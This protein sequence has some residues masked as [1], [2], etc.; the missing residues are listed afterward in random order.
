MAAPPERTMAAAAAGAAHRAKRRRAVPKRLEESMRSP[1]DAQATP[2]AALRRVFGGL[3]A[4]DWPIL[5][6]IPQ[7]APS[8]SAA[9]A[10]GRRH[11]LPRAGRR[12]PARRSPR[13][14]PARGSSAPTSPGAAPP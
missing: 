12:R 7:F 8:F 10:P 5:E 11:A 3:L 13:R 4:A 6:E 9:V 14:A 2:L 1:L